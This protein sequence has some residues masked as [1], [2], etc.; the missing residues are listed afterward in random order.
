MN[1]NASG[2]MYSLLVRLTSG[3]AMYTTENIVS[4]SIDNARTIFFNQKLLPSIKNEILNSEGLSIEHKNGSL[5]VSASDSKDVFIFPE[6]NYYDKMMVRWIK[7]IT[8]QRTLVLFT[9]LSILLSCIAVISIS[10]YLDEHG[11]GFLFPEVLRS[12]STANIIYGAFWPV[13]LIIFS[14]FIFIILNISTYYIIKSS[15]NQF[16]Y[17]NIN[18]F[19]LLIFLSLCL[20]IILLVI[21]P[22][23]FG[24]ALYKSGNALL[25]IPFYILSSYVMYLMLLFL[26]GE[27][28]KDFK[29][30]SI[31]LTLFYHGIFFASVFYM[32]NKYSFLRAHFWIEIGVLLIFAL[33]FSISTQLSTITRVTKDK[34]F[35][36]VSSVVILFAE[37]VLLS[38]LFILT[39][40]KV[41]DYI[42]YA[43]LGK[44]Y[45][46]IKFEPD[47]KSY[48]KPIM[49]EKNQT[50]TK[51]KPCTKFELDKDGYFNPWVV[52]NSENY[53]VI[54]NK[55]NSRLL[56]VFHKYPYR[57]DSVVNLGLEKQ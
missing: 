19:V 46:Y 41:L 10:G 7:K 57:L 36:L 8:L 49:C 18:Y 30:F 40:M 20:D 9:F 53:L 55:P 15:K 48:L 42:E 21:F 54:S 22:R 47:L 24:Y 16:T 44:Y 29:E 28:K 3:N 35:R 2:S 45:Q 1:L 43:K 52:L 34:K 14:L 25:L 37:L 31:L 50:S 5:Y 32:H 27:Q 26:R 33:A 23:I 17:Q 13:T 11:L 12:L 38:F 39:S 6:E 56:L 51:N 4:D